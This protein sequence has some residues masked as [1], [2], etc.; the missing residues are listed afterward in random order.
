MGL[1]RR[2]LL[3]LVLL[4]AGCSGATPT[5]QIIYVTAPPQ[6]PTVVYVTPAAGSEAPASP[7]THVLDGTVTAVDPTMT[8][9]FGH[10]GGA[11]APRDQP[12]AGV[13]SGTGVTVKDA[14][15]VVIGAA[16]LGT[17]VGVEDERACAWAFILPLPTSDF[18]VFTVGN[19]GDFPESYTALEGAG[20]KLNLS[21]GP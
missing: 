7:I 10:G 9:P 12:F 11:C 2:R 4:L 21:V 1:A 14:H 5:P 6:T 8:I 13:Q 15:G 19:H 20:W 3:A 16:I 17:G 18:Y